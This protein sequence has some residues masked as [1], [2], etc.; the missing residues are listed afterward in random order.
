M[1]RILGAFSRLPPVFADVSIM[2]YFSNLFSGDTEGY[3]GCGA[4]AVP[5]PCWSCQLPGSMVTGSSW[6]GRRP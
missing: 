3:A 4:E 2:A 5:G 1:R 6:G